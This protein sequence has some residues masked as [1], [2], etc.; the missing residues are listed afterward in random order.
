MIWLCSINADSTTGKY[1]L[2]KVCAIM[3]MPLGI[4]PFPLLKQMRYN[5]IPEE[6]QKTIT[7]YC[8]LLLFDGYHNKNFIFLHFYLAKQTEINYNTSVIWI[9][10]FLKWF[11]SYFC[12]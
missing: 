3:C 4:L 10:P 5:S 6:E 8:F 11:L 12:K 7:G 9:A 1:D 2:G